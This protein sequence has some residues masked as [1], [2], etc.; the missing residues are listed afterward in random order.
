MAESLT[1]EVAIF[2]PTTEENNK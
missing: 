2:P 1:V